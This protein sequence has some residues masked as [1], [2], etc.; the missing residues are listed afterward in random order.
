M[1]QY[2]I[3]D[4]EPPACTPGSRVFSIP[5]KSTCAMRKAGSSPAILRTFPGIAKHIAKPN[6]LGGMWINAAKILTVG[7]GGVLS[8]TR[9]EALSCSICSHFGYAIHILRR[10]PGFAYRREHR[11]M[12]VAL[13]AW[14]PCGAGC[15]PAAGCQPALGFVIRFL[16]FP[17]RTLFSALQLLAVLPSRDRKGVSMGLRPTKG[18]EDALWQIRL[19]GGNACPT[20]APVGQALS[21]ANRRLQRSRCPFWLRQPSQDSIMDHEN[22]SDPRGRRKITNC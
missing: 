11:A 17:T 9:T 15:H 18:D 3:S 6:P 4:R 20:L 19:A 14:R 8:H 16:L 7:R 21:P 12:P 22:R 10:S 5:Q 2:E 13:R 1:R